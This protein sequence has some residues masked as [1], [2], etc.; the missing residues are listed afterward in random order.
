MSPPTRRGAS[1][2]K[3]PQ[4]AAAAT[5]QAQRHRT[6]TVR[7]DVYVRPLPLRARDLPVECW[8]L[9]SQPWCEL[10]LKRLAGAW[11]TVYGERAV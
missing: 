1:A 9:K 5:P 2:K 3:A 11:A 6:P 4:E 8:W 10:H 7:P